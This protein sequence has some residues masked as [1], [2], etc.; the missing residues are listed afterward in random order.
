MSDRSYLC[1]IPLPC[2]G[3]VMGAASHQTEG[4]CPRV[5]RVH[6]LGGSGVHLRAAPHRAHL[7]RPC[8]FIH[9]VVGRVK[10]KM[11][12]L[13]TVTNAWEGEPGFEC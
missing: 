3:T 11:Y 7:T 6:G 13:L 4:C 1:E 10:D 2:E 8:A 9:L 12:L 5:G